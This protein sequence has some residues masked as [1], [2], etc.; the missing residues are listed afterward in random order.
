M[1]LS[2]LKSYS[3]LALDYWTTTL[4]TRLLVLTTS[5]EGLRTTT[6]H[7]L[8]WAFS[9]SVLRF[10]F[11][12]WQCCVTKRIILSL[13]ADSQ[14]FGILHGWQWCHL[15]QQGMRLVRG[16]RERVNVVNPCVEPR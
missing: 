2:L 9:T 15:S 5:Y 13:P 4:P 14:D 10:W 16:R 3:L 12:E 11:E 1:V 7:A 8:V 6:Y